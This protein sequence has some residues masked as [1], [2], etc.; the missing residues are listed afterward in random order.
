[1][2]SHQSF[3]TLTEELPYRVPPRHV[4]VSTKDYQFYP[5]SLMGSELRIYLPKMED[6]VLADWFDRKY[7][8]KKSAVI[9]S[10]MRKHKELTDSGKND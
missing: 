9:R 1:M 10:L 5:G 2:I 6:V 7:G 4:F 3:L 8:S